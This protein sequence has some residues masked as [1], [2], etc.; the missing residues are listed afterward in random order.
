MSDTTTKDEVTVSYDY[1]LAATTKG[2]VKVSDSG[3]TT[4]VP[5]DSITDIQNITASRTTIT[6]GEVGK[7]SAELSQTQRDYLAR[8]LNL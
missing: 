8:K 5:L 2:T 7:F 3:M 6:V 1:A 4:Q